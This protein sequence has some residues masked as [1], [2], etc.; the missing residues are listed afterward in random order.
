MIDLNKTNDMARLYRLFITVPAGLPCLKRA[1]KDSIRK[2]GE[3]IN[4][5]S[6][7]IEG[8][9]GETASKPR[10]AAGAQ[11]LALALKWVQDVLDL[12]DLFDKIWREALSCDRELE[13]TLNEVCHS[14]SKCLQPGLPPVK[15]FETFININDRSSEF[16]SLF[17]D[18]NLRRGLRGVSLTSGF[19]P[20]LTHGSRQS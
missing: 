19:T 3:V 20:C 5:T 2:R 8:A 11:T 10:P 12:K 15:A 14:V 9:D 1:L 18:D 16:I 13:S 6:S 4:Q 7:M 17:I